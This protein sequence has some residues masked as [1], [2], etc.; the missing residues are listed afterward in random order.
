M[1]NRN[2]LVVDLDLTQ[3]TGRA[4]R[5]AALG[6]LDRLPR[7]KRRL[8]LGGDKGYDTHEFVAE[9]RQ[10]RVTPHVTQNQSGRRSAMDGR[11]TSWGGYAVS[12]RLRKR[13]KEI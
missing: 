3:A 5:E 4:E 11:T 9:L 2:G 10:R 1:E 6:M 7:R 12:Q 8:T 13:G